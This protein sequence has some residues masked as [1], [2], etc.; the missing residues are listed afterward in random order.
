M[1][2]FFITLGVGLTAVAAVLVLVSYGPESVRRAGQTTISEAPHVEYSALQ[3][4]D[5]IYSSEAG[6]VSSMPITA[7]AYVIKDVKTGTISADHN[8]DKLLPIASLTKLVTAAVA[9]TL[10]ARDTRITITPDIV[11]MFGNASEFKVGETLLSQDLLYPLLMDSS[12]E[13][14]EAYARYYGRARFIVAM[15]Q[16]TQTIGAYRTHF[17]DPSGLSAHNVSTA[18]DVALILDWLRLH[19]PA[20]FS[21]TLLKSKTVRTHT[22][23]NPAHF[24][25]WSNY[26][27]G[28]NGYTTEADRTAAA[29][30]RLGGSQDPY[31]VVVLGSSER[32]GDVIKLLRMVK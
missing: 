2:I 9:N 11:R 14:A 22:W 3:E 26:L 1:K 7:T 4:E 24:L 8:A 16:F 15:N 30:F 18:N 25:N 27:G 23:T 20:I 32:D 29:V 12:N 21:I 17:D 5:L 13:A 19:D 6:P 31:A 28:K 10:I